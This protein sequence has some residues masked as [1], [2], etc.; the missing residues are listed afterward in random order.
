VFVHFTASFFGQQDSRDVWLNLRS[1]RGLDRT[2]RDVDRYRPECNMSKIIEKPLSFYADKPVLVTGHT[3]FKGSWLC[4]WL[5][6]LGARVIGYALVPPTD[7]NMFEALRLEEKL[8]HVLGDVRDSKRLEACF[9]RYK[10][11]IVFHMAAQPIVRRSYREPQTT[12][13]TNVMG[14]VNLL[15][16]VRKTRSAKIVVVVTSD[17]CYEDREQH[18][19]YKET[20]LLGGRDP[21]SSSKACAEL[22]VAAYRSSFF[23]LGRDSRGVAVASVRAGNVVGGGDWGEDRLLPD[24]IRALNAGKKILIRN[25]ASVRPWQHVL[26]PLSGYLLLGTKLDKDREKFAAA[27]NFGPSENENF[28][29]EEIARKVIGYWGSGTYDAKPAS[30]ELKEAS[31]LRLDCRKAREILGWEPTYSTDDAIRASVAWYKKFYQGENPLKLYEFTVEQ[32]A[33]YVARGG[34]KLHPRR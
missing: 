11:Q 25:P 34:R 8:V 1:H 22:V 10:P 14:T 7:P 17:K 28:T 16:A 18:L 20:D 24:C 31:L 27:W 21:Y 13:E 26:E 12:F 9:N 33:E 5:N 3:G 4:T 19:G 23:E 29:V 6:E 2:R 30:K 32:I 15:E